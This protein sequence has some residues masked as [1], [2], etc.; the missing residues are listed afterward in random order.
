VCEGLNVSRVWEEMFWHGC[1]ENTHH[2][3]LV[4][5]G[6]LY[7]DTLF[8]TDG[9]MVL[10]RPSRGCMH[11]KTNLLLLFCN[12]SFYTFLKNLYNFATNLLN[13]GV[14]RFMGA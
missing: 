13:K 4:V 11:S 9:I 1:L 14:G 3:F 2:F 12:F 6:H 7:L 5:D 8:P 10:T